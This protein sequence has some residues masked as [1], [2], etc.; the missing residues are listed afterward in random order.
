M[1]ELRRQRLVDEFDGEELLFMDGFDRCIMGVCLQ[2]GRETVVAY[3]LEKVL[4]Q[5]MMEDMSRKEAE[6]FWSFNQLGAYCREYTPVFI[7]RLEE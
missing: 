3:D 1:D 5:L 4:E 2:F 7:R 6:E